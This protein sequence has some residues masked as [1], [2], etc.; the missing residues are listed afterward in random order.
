M[1]Q[2][3]DPILTIDTFKKGVNQELDEQLIAHDEAS[4]MTNCEIAT[5]A[6]KRSKGVTVYKSGVKDTA[7]KL[8]AHHVSGVATIMTGDNLGKI[9]KDGLVVYDGTATN[10]KWKHINYQMGMTDVTI[11]TNGESEV[12]LYDS[13]NGF[14]PLLNSLGDKDVKSYEEKDSAS[15]APKG[16]YICLHKERVWMANCANDEDHGSNAVVFS[17]DMDPNDWQ[18][19]SAGTEVNQHG[20]IIK[21][22]TWDGG[23]IIGLENL[24]DDVIVFKNHNVFRIFGTHP[25]NYELIQLFQTTKGEIYEDT[26]ASMENS[27][28]WL[29]TEG[30]FAF[31]GTNTIP[32]H[33]RIQ[34]YFDRIK[35]DVIDTAIATTWNGK[36]IISLPLDDATYANYTFEYD[37]VDGTWTVRSGMRPISF[38]KVEQDLLFKTSNNVNVSKYESGEN[39]NGTYINSHWESGWI[40]FG[41]QNAKKIVTKLYFTGNG[42]GNVKFSLIT[43]RKTKEKTILLSDEKT[44]KVR[45][46]NKG[47]LFKIKIENVDGSDFTIKRPQFIYDMDVD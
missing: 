3:Q 29:S 44:H 12:Q 22:P 36:Y 38:L 9:Y 40:D 26:I 30:I 13:T 4:D 5:G 43:E 1:S 34:R 28:F 18:F 7:T 31:N 6:L 21:I 2:Q 16:K 10:A 32:I 17:T 25:E 45:L 27:S 23:E 15:R 20:G 24:F 41:V 42:N 37:L 35:W 14:R 19:P 11:F 46:K 8:M 33:R 39:Y 47:R